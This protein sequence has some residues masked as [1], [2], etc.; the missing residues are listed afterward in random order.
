[1]E[2]VNGTASFLRWVVDLKEELDRG[3]SRM[4]GT[5]PTKVS[6]KEAVRPEVE[7]TGSVVTVKMDLPGVAPD[8]VDL[9]LSRRETLVVSGIVR[10]ASV[11]APLYGLEDLGYDAFREVVELPASHGTGEARATFE[12]GVLEVSLGGGESDEEARRFRIEES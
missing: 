11:E 6:R 8:D 12:D 1:M 4:R 7:R 10:P 2:E 5:E 3:R 9:T